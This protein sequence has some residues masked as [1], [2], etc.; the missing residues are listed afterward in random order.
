MAVP[1]TTIVNVALPSIAKGVQAS[2]DALE[3]VVSGYALAFGLV[4]VPAGRIG[5]WLGHKQV[6]VAGLT[7]FTVASVACRIAQ[8][9]AKL[10][11]ARLVQASVRASITRPSARLFSGGSRET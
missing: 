11:A 3:W 5:D 10:I 9:P 2:S 7:L 8:N 6:F 1:D 4:M